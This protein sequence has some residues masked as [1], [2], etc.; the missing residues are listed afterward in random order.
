[1]LSSLAAIALLTLPLTG[2]SGGTTPAQLP[3][4]HRVPIGLSAEFTSEDPA[5]GPA[6]ALNRIEIELSRRVSLRTVGRPL[7][8]ERLLYKS[9]K[10]V[11][12]ECGGSL[13]GRGTVVSDIRTSAYSE[14]TARVEGEMQEYYGLTKEDEPM[15]LVAHKMSHLHGLCARGHPNC[16]ADPY[17]VNGIYSRIASMQLT[18][19]RVGHS[20]FISGSCPRR[21]VDSATS[22]MLEQFVLHYAGGTQASGEVDGACR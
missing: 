6:P 3:R 1:L 7:C 2:F 12:E 18:L 21:S 19:R 4:G 10:A 20:A 5:G 22:F 16:F 17:G 9:T 15:I 8:R 14:Q 13:V 11:L